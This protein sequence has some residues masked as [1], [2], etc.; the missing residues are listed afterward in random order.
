MLKRDGFNPSTPDLFDTAIASVSASLAFQARPAASGSALLRSKHRKSLLAHSKVPIPEPQ[1]CALV[2]TPGSVSGLF[3]E[4]L[5]DSMAAQVKEDSLV[6]PPWPFLRLC[7]PAP[8][9]SLWLRLHRL[10]TVPSGYCPPRPAQRSGKRSA[11]SSR[12]GGRRRFKGGKRSAPSSNPSGFRKL[13]R[14]PCL[15]LSS[16][17]LSLR[18]RAWRDRGA[19]SWVVE[20]LRE[21][22]RIPFLRPPPLS[23]DPIPMPSYAPLP[24][25]GLFSRRSPWC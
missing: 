4:P 1:K 24:S 8:V 2:V 13:V 11:S 21:G 6:S 16:G 25:K 15:T 5:L 22:C 19:Y 9:R 18:W 14:L 3:D 17:C 12:S 23:T 7:P 20:V 10:S